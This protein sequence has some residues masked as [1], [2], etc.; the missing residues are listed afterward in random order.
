MDQQ[1]QAYSD[2]RG[3]YS[4]ATPQQLAREMN[5]GSS[6]PQPPSSGYGYEAYQTPSVPSHTQSMATSPIGSPR[7]RTHSGDG[8]VAMEDA[9]P[10]NRLKYPSRPSHQHRTSAPYLPHEDSSAARRYSPMKALS[11]SNHF[12]QTPQ[13]QSQGTFGAYKSQNSSA[14]QSPNRSNAYPTPAQSYYPSPGEFCFPYQA[15]K[16]NGTDNSALASSRQQPLHLP[17][18]QVGELSPDQYYPSSATAQLNAVFG[19]EAKSPR[20]PRQPYGMGQDAPRGSV[21]RFKKLATVKDLEP[22]VNPQP[23]FRRANPEGGFISV[24]ML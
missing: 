10:Y 13:Q 11:P 15:S 1:W 7:T 22:R 20:H 16:P 12:P 4:H 14:R 19:R 3:R 24:R 17:P 6:Q 8:D 18:I 5:N 23:A 21:P 2:S 9:D